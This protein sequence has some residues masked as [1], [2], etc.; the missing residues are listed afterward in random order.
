[1]NPAEKKQ[2]IREI[3]KRFAEK[4]LLLSPALLEMEIKKEEE[5]GGSEQISKIIEGAKGKDML[6]PDEESLSM[7][8]K[9]KDINWTDFE[10]AK[11]SVE[12]NNDS[13]MYD[14]F[15]EYAKKEEPEKARQWLQRCKR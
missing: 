5:G 7:L 12:K 11:T 8:E 13:R 2:R 9:N 6:V 15:V 4:G 1:M 10:K 3:A 14:K